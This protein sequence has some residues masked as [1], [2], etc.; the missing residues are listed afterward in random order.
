MR[1][2]FEAL[3][4]YAVFRG[5]ASRR[6]Y[7]MFMLIHLTIVV[8][9]ASTPNALVAGLLVNVYAI[10]TLIPG[11]ALLVRRMHDAGWSGWWAIV[12]FAC[13]IIALRDS[14]PCANRYGANPKGARA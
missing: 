4:K 3:Q 11:V 9:L 8:L 7:W 13:T 14:E 6:E 2:Y 1:S 5:R 10:G 12:P